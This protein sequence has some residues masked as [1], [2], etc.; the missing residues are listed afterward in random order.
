[1][2]YIFDKITSMSESVEQK[3]GVDRKV[4]ITIA[5][6]GTLGFCTGVALKK[7]KLIDPTFPK[8]SVGIAVSGL[9]AYTISKGLEKGFFSEKEYRIGN[10]SFMR[11]T[12]LRY[13]GH[14]LLGF[15]SGLAV[16]SLT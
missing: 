8:A 15:G 14:F 10:I 9:A 1:M 16:S 6:G 7:A 13:T 5:L 2:S 12:L 4:V 3:S 11:S